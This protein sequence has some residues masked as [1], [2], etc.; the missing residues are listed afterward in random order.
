MQ[1]RNPLAKWLLHFASSQRNIDWVAIWFG[2]T[3]SVLALAWA[4]VVLVM[5]IFW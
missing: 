3:V 1:W 5:R 4:V 2:G